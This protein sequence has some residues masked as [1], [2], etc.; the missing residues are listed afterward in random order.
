MFRRLLSLCLLGSAGC[1]FTAYEKELAVGPPEAAE[2]GTTTLAVAAPQASWLQFLDV[3]HI[4][5]SLVELFKHTT[6][7]EAVR[8]G[9]HYVER[10]RFLRLEL[11]ESR[12]YPESG[13]ENAP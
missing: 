5:D 3:N 12:R 13:D 7:K 9:A 8:V 2:A 11:G 1:T 4:V 10:T 6:A